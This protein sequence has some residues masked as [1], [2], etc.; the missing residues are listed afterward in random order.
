[1]NSGRQ[2]VKGTGTILE[3]SH[4]LAWITTA[5][6]PSN[7]R[8]DWWCRWTFF[9]SVTFSISS[10]FWIIMSD[11]TATLINSPL[12]GN[13]REGTQKIERKGMELEGEREK[14]KE[15]RER[16]KREEKKRRRV[17]WTYVVHDWMTILDPGSRVRVIPGIEKSE[18]VSGRECINGPREEK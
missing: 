1:M 11:W 6:P 16:E 2:V 17:I 13:M 12:A 15:K 14:K 18:T 5:F 8:R 4:S 7:F 9:F 10:S 3:G